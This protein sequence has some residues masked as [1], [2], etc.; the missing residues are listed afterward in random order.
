MKSENDVFI[1]GIGCVTPLGTSPNVLLDAIRAGQTAIKPSLFPSEIFYCKNNA[2]VSNIDVESLIRD[3]K[4]LRLMN[5]DAVF[6]AA[7]ARLAIEDAGVEIDKNIQGRRVGLFGSTGLM[8]L[9]L[10]EISPV[11]RASL[12]SNGKL[13]PKK[14]GNEG[15]KATRP[16]LSFKILSNMPVC[17]VSILEKI[18][19]P[20]AIFNPWEG[21]GALAIIE[22]VRAISTGEADC[23]L[24]GGCDQKANS[25]GFLSLQQ[26]G[27]F[28]SWKNEG[29]GTAPSEGAVF[30]FLESSSS[31]NRR[32]V[33]PYATIK[34]WKAGTIKRNLHSVED[35]KK[36]L[37]FLLKSSVPRGASIGHL[38]LSGDNGTMLNKLEEETFK[39]FF[40]SKPEIETVFPKHHLGNLFAAAAA[41]QLAVGAMMTRESGYASVANCLGHGSTT[42]TFYLENC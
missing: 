31:A 8:C 23:A 21:Q 3:P 41:G 25:M 27:V 33:K 26:H 24:A 30:L 2:R 13:D 22:A 39:G 5:R 6:A 35:E 17:F 15:L 32:K 18:R 36:V 37:E 40:G 14:L 12:D 4:S 1:T 29:T 19:G 42:A 28:D 10:E 11:L 9:P 34:G 38:I 20:N 16:V 7:A